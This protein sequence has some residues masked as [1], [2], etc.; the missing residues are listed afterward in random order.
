MIKKRVLYIEDNKFDRLAFERYMRQVPAI[1]YTVVNTIKE[2]RDMIM[3]NELDIIITDYSLS[4]GTAFDILEMNLDIPVIVTTGTGSEEIAVRLMRTGA[5]DYL[6]K[7]VESNY[8]KMLPVVIENTLK[9]LEDQRALLRSK[10]ELE[11]AMELQRKKDEFIGIASHELKTPLTSAKAYIQLMNQQLTLEE[12][13]DR[14]RLHQWVNKTESYVTKLETLIGNLLDVSKLNAGKMQYHYTEFALSEMID[15]AVDSAKH[16]FNNYKFTIL[17][18]PDV[19]VRG[20]KLRLEQVLTNFLTNAVKY[21]PGKDEVIIKSSAGDGMITIAVQDFGIGIAKEAQL[22]VFDRFFRVDDVSHRFS[23]LGVG[24][25][26]S[27]EI[28][29]GHNGKVWL[30]SEEGKGSTFYFRIPIE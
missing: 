1:Q 27:H 16:L 7:D 17:P 23:G 26:I 13:I 28:V 19:K 18:V 21:S 6:I 22:K 9:Y 20:D 12:E 30:E 8:L 24:L 3:G 15:E 4:D 10:V 11:Q 2:A 5:R 29:A 25:Y 14:E